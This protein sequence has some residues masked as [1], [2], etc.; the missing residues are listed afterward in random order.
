MK[1]YAILDHTGYNKTLLNVVEKWTEQGHKVILDMYYDAAKADWADV[2]FG[3]Y[4][5]G[6]VVGAVNDPNLKTP[7]VMTQI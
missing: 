7:I 2:V 4:I 3:E 1:I 5:Q 6:G